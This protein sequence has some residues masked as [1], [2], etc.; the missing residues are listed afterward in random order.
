MYG[1]ALWA[2]QS[3]FK[4]SREELREIIGDGG[5]GP[6]KFG[7]PFVPDNLAGIDIGPC[8]DI[9]DYMYDIGK[10]QEDKDK[11]D[12]LFLWNMVSVV[13]TYTQDVQVKKFRLWLAKMYYHA[14]RDHGDSSFWKN[15]G[16]GYEEEIISR[17]KRDSGVPK[18]I[19]DNHSC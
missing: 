17:E 15:K 11:A 3:Y 10:T 2:P 8:C 4:L 1:V 6:G 5:C 7:D 13:S 18:I 14:V 16:V 12:Q 9:H 19:S